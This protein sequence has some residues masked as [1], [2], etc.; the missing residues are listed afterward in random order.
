MKQRLALAII[1]MAM[2]APFASRA[3]FIDEHIYLRLGRAALERPL[4]PADTPLLFFGVTYPDHAGH[5]HPPVG[6]YFLAGI[7]AA[8]GSFDEVPFRLLY[9]LFSVAAIL[10]FYSLARRFSKE[11]FWVSTLL[12]V[13]PAFVVLSPTLMMD[14]PMLAFLLAGFAFY[15][16]SRLVPA[17][18]C[19]VLATGTGYTAL[20]PI[21]CL[22]LVL[23]LSGRPWKE[24]ACVAAPAL[25][26]GIWLL[27]M[28]IH[29]GEF[30]LKQTLNYLFFREAGLKPLPEIV[31]EKLYTIL[32]NFVAIVSF[33]G[34]VSIIPG[35]VRL[36]EFRSW[37]GA[38]C[39]A[40]ILSVFAPMPSLLYRLWFV[41]LATCGLMLLAAFVG[42]AYGL[43]QRRDRNGGEAVL[44]LWVPS[45]L[46]F[47]ALVGEMI[48]A[49]YILLVLPALFLIVFRESSRSQLAGIVIPTACLSL[50]LACADARFVN[51]YRDWVSQMVPGLQ[52]D[53]FRVF[54]ATESGL[55]FY[56]EAAGADTLSARDLRP[57]GS[58]LIVRSKMFR[59]SL[60]EDVEVVSTVLRHFRLEDGFPVRTFNPEARAGF[61]DS[62]FGMAPF[63]LSWEP[64]DE[65]EV[66]QIN[67]LVEKLPQ[68]STDPEQ[69][70]V[71]SPSG[72]LYIQ[73]ESE[74]I[75]RIKLPLNMEI[76]YERQE[77]TGFAE[78]TIDGFRLVKTDGIRIEW[79]R[80][81]F[82][83]L[84]L[85]ENQD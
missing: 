53:G 11:P 85:M 10:A 22:A 23:C 16:Q 44:I 12:A 83:P 71:W 5:T 60:A 15:F 13:S 28:T 36:R 19:F 77:G 9:A 82:M 31:K 55:R 50:T 40:A 47:F 3:V 37:A 67:P 24:V 61:Y 6:E 84:K 46:L 48:N 54:S 66:T 70:P 41:V 2:V 56:L 20:V 74:L 33:V 34:G 75:F 51:S 49:R 80:L 27:A 81:R 29:F 72:P 43:I 38:V 59:Y 45:V 64:H 39:L 21:A 57:A 17:A 14:I 69:V 68:A 8:L 52:S 7:F 58:D 65:I 30:P 63:V 26:L 18:V 35:G 78:K 1:V 76:Q 62:R 25:A 4:F 79:R 73:T 42:S 32:L